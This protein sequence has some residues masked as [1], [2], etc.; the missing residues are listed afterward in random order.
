[1]FFNICIYRIANPYNTEGWDCKS[2]QT[3]ITIFSFNEGYILP[4][5]R[6]DISGRTGIIYPTH[7]H[8]PFLI[9]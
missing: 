7:K 2:Q 3:S 8:Y 6:M 5:G 9:Y 4:G 1:M